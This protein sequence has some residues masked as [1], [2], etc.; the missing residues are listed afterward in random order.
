[1]PGRTKQRPTAPGTTPDT[2]APPRF[3]LWREVLIAYAAPAVMATAG[4]MATGQSELRIA[5]LTTIAGTSALVAT[6]VGLRHRRRSADS[7]AARGPIPL[8]ALA[9]GLG[10]AA[11][12]LAVGLAA[13]ELLPRIPAL[14]DSPWPGRLRI[15]LPLSAA[16]AATM[17]TWRWRVSLPRRRRAH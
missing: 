10:C 6:L 4:G 8:R 5:A 7:W 12:A 16:I 11:L 9:F 14:A 15:D 17:T 2:A 3:V 13:A 1:M